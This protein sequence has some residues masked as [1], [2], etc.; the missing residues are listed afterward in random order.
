MI[1]TLAFAATLFSANAAAAAPDAEMRAALKELV[2]SQE[3]EKN[4]PLI[5]DALVQ[6]GVAEIKRGL[7]DAL[8]RNP[9]LTDS[10]RAR[11][12]G[13]AA[14]MY[15]PMAAEILASQKNLDVNALMND[16]TLQVYP[17]YFTAGEIRAMSKFY[18]S[19]AFKK[20]VDIGNRVNAEAARTGKS[21]DSLYP[22]YL[23]QM[24]REEQATLT[25]FGNSAVGKKQQAVGA[26]VQQESLALYSQR[27]APDIDAIAKR[28][29]EKLGALMREAQ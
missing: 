2:A 18:R 9:A 26:A 10:Q 24:S 15:A 28:F 16:T 5:L 8:E 4:W 20:M 19:S 14:E 25:A 13:L 11:A 17:K 29:G 6:S 21:A 3:L 1:S 23:A 27:T 7:V 22:K 12:L